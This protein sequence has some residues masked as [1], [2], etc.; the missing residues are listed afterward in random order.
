VIGLNG[1]A[2]N[3]LRRRKELGELTQLSIRQ[4]NA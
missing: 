2:L 3:E 4:F 1:S